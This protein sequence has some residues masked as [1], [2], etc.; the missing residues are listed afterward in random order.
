MARILDWPRDLHWVSREPLS[1]PRT[2]GAGSSE[3]LTGFTQ[4]FASPF[5]LWR[6]SFSFPPLKGRAFRH[7]RGT[8]TALHGG[9][10]ALRVP[11][12]DPDGMTWSEIGVATTPAQIRAGVPWSNGQPW[13]NGQNWRVGRPWVPFAAAAPADATEI[14]LASAHWGH[15]LEIGAMIGAA[16]FHFGLYVVTEA[17][18]AGRYRIWPPLRRSVTTADRA[19]LEPVLAMRL[20]SESAAPAPRGAVNASGLAVTLVEIGDSDLRRWVTR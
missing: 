19:T 15:S 3:S 8:M 7:Y 13:A 9:A 20:E 4:S 1:G 16:P 10:N 5:G 14:H 12:C 17:M 2:I 18:G 11:F 6:W